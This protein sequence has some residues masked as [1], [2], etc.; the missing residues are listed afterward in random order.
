MIGLAV[1]EI[2]KSAESGQYGVEASRDPTWAAKKVRPT[3]EQKPSPNSINLLDD[4][5]WR[6]ERPYEQG[7]P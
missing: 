7:A 4:R 5:G 3:A 2:V 1:K 6:R